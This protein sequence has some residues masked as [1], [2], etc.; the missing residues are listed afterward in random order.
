MKPNFI[1]VMTDQQRADLRSSRGFT[2]DT[3]PFLDTF[4]CEGVDFESA[5]TANPTC[6][7]ARVSMFTGRYPESHRV[8]TNFNARDAIYSEDMLD[9][10]K[11][12]GYKTALC[13]KNH[14]HHRPSDFDFARVNGHLGGEGEINRSDAEEEFSAFLKK[15]KHLETYEPSPGGVEVQ[16]PYR[17][18]TDALEFIDSCKDDPFFLWISMAEPHNPW[19]VPEPY[20]DMFEPENLPPITGTEALASKSERFTWLRGIWE[21]ISDD[22]D[23]RLCRMRSNYYGMLRL[24]DDQLRRLDEGLNA[25]GLYENTYVVFISDHGDFVGEYGLLRKGPELP[26]LLVN[27]PMIWR[28]PGI[29]KNVREKRFANIVDILPTFCDILGVKTPVGVQGK[30]ILPLLTGE[31]IP[32]GEYDIAYSESGFGGLRWTVEDSLSPADEGACPHDYSAFDCLNTWTQCGKCRMIRYGDYK[33]QLDDTG[34]GYLYN[35]SVDPLE[36]NNLWG[37]PE[38][39]E[40]SLKMSSML[41]S[42]MMRHYDVLPYPHRRYRV[43]IHPK[44]FVHQKYITG[45]CGVKDISCA[46]RIKKDSE[47]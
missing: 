6:M 26:Q 39:S 3:M 12:A 36:L 38:Y 29:R 45:D 16:F 27:I 43:K 19:Q 18:I 32:D 8:R 24:I 11:N 7:P 20:F 33:L 5:Y 22:I 30:S 40:I 15:T 17:N 25:R 4:A 28:G 13:G 46:V 14:S 34:E 31:N 1:I 42:E 44:G 37:K 35:L 47:K 23:T 41:A 9:I 2:L 21:R 10:F